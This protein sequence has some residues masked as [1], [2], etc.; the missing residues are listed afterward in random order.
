MREGPWGTR[1]D[2][3]TARG[4]GGPTRHEVRRARGLGYHRVTVPCRRFPE[5]PMRS[6]QPLPIAPGFVILALGSATRPTAPTPGAG[7]SRVVGPEREAP[8]RRD[9][10]TRT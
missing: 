8:L 4:G 3:T 6:I 5:F 1:R 9:G 2:A 10:N 7:S